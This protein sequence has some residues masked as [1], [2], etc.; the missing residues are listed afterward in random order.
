MLEKK[1]LRWENPAEIYVPGFLN[2]RQLNPVYV[3]VLEDS[4]TKDG[5]LPTFPIVCFRRLDLPY[6]DNYTS[7]LYVCAAG[8]HRTTAAQ[9]LEL[10][11]V[12]IDL[13]TG[14]MDDFLEAMHTDNFQFDPAID[15]SLGQLFTKTEKR[16]ACKQLLLLPKYLKLTNVALAEMWHTSE[17]NIR[18]WRDEMASSINEAPDRFG[19]EHYPDG[20][21]AEIQEILDSNVRESPDGSIVKVRS[22]S[23]TEKWDYYM[24]IQEKVRAIP[25]LDWNLDVVPYIEKVYDEK[26]PSDLSLKKLAE[27]DMLISD[28]DADFLEKCRLFGKA[29]REL[30]A[31]RDAYRD[32]FRE[33]EDAFETY[34]KS[35][36]LTDDS[37][38]HY[39]DAYKACLKSFGR[40]VSRNFG[41]NLLGSKIYEDT[42]AKYKRETTQLN[43]LT[44]HIE[45][46]A[47]YV[48]EFAQR[49]LKRAQKKR[50]TLEEGLVTAQ[51]ALLTAAKEKYPDLDLTKFV[52]AVD[53]DSFW[54]DMGTTLPFPMDVSH[55]PE[56]K[57][58]KDIEYIR[59]HYEEMRKQ[60]EKGE[61]WI[62]RLMVVEAPE[63]SRQ[64][65]PDEAFKTHQ[66][67]PFQ[68]ALDEMKV[69]DT[70]AFDWKSVRPDFDPEKHEW[71]KVVIQRGKN[72]TTVTKIPTGPA[73]F[74]YA[75]PETEVVIAE[76]QFS[77]EELTEFAAEL[78]E[79]FAKWVADKSK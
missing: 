54:L 17:G 52:L 39:S 28:R 43:E 12:Y 22:K 53:S 11:K 5:F 27:L 18:R 70:E 37:S 21:L 78:S 9:N 69:S 76:G 55:I 42:A 10:E 3:E 14:T 46:N 7:E 34:I 23:K 49:Y 32:A 20:R 19:F 75:F 30:E 59:E 79:I 25:D 44:S 4:M 33:C 74:S 47:D 56:G 29:Q 2:N 67:V 62:Q 65:S 45:K 13:R 57:K 73:L 63:E 16:E 1:E 64:G 31:S 41:R 68:N 8:A 35:M 38:R 71:L 77:V 40:V 50:R 26:Y 58:D 48:Q 51:H 72:H 15:T 6:F 61:E 60:V 24:G 66:G 36:G